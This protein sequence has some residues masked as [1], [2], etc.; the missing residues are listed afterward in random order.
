[1]EGIDVVGHYLY[2]ISKIYYT[3]FILDLKSMTYRNV[4][5]QQGLFDGQPDQVDVVLNNYENGNAQYPNTISETFSADTI[6]LYFTE[7]TNRTAGIHGRT[8][9]GDYVTILQSTY[10]HDETVG[11][12]FSPNYQY[13]YMGYQNAGIIFQISRTDTLPFYGTTL[14]VK[15]HNGMDNPSNA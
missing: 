8:I 11:L 15:Y 4:T 10:Y 5:T 9:L 3:M 7:D 13:M 6:L 12:A 1:V 2:F 14:N